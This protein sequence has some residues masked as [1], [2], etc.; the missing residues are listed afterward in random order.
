MTRQIIDISTSTIIRF[1]LVVLAVALLYFLKSFVVMVFAALI[2]AVAFDRPVD[3][4]E[5]RG[6]PRILG[7][8]FVYLALFAVIAFLFYLVFPVLALQIKNLINNYSFYLWRVGQLQP[9]SG[10]IDIQGVVS[11]FAEGLTASADAF[12]G[13]IVAF[14]GGIIS[15]LTILVVAIFLNVQENGVKKFVFYLAPKKNQ[16]YVLNLFEKIQQKVGNWFW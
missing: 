15:F 16:G 12:W 3:V 4:L 5:K 8:S 13:T 9:K 2:L 6:V 14:F 1:V 11:Q 7:V 10:V